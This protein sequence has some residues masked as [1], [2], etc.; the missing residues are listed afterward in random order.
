MLGFQNQ[1]CQLS[2]LR[3]DIFLWAICPSFSTFILPVGGHGK[4]KKIK[5]NLLTDFSF[6]SV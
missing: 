1:I 4:I 5:R 3:E 6:K 2:F